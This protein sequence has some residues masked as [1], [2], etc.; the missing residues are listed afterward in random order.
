MYFEDFFDG[1]KALREISQTGLNPSNLRLID[2]F[3]SFFMGIGDGSNSVLLIGFENASYPNLNQMLDFCLEICVKNKGKIDKSIKDKKSDPIWRENFTTLPYVRNSLIPKGIIMETLETVCNW[4]NFKRLYDKMIKE[5]GKLLTESSGLGF[6]TCR[7]THCY[8]DGLAPYFTIINQGK[9]GKMSEQWDI[10]KRK[11]NDIIIEYQGSIT[12]HHAVG[13]D[14][15]E[16]YSLQSDPLFL[17]VLAKI[18]KT[19]DPKGIMNPG[20]LIPIVKL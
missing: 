12:H 18:K 7:I 17:R 3:E 9:Q 11:A 5:I 15:V 1:I 13:K 20:V 10:I 6:I 2:S 19:L 8:S 14:H 16:H 4:S